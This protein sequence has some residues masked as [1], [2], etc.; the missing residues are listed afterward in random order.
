MEDLT[1]V[2][3]PIAAVFIL[4]AMTPGPSLFIVLRNTM[5]GGRMRGVYCAVGHGIGFGIYVF[6]ALMGMTALFGEDEFMYDMMG[7]VGVI[8]LIY[9]SIK[10]WTAEKYEE[11]SMKEKMQAISMRA[12]FFEGFAIA[13][14]NPKIVLFLVAILSQFITADMTLTT[15]LTIVAIGTIIDGTWY[16]LV[17]LALTGTKVLRKLQ[18]LGSTLN[19]LSSIILIG[20]AAYSIYQMGYF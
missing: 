3:L 9:F 12:G 1:G 16:I 11:E 2:I 13:F 17:A 8:L 19:K 5:I 7:S 6:L 10:M 15:K 4:G 18:S 14:F 20:F